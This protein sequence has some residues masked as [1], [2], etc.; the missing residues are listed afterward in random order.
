MALQ[1]VALVSAFITIVSAIVDAIKEFPE[2]KFFWIGG[3]AVFITIILF[4]ILSDPQIKYLL[5]KIYRYNI[6]R[7][8]A[9]IIL[10]KHFVYTYKSMTTLAYKKT[11]TI[12]S[13]V[14][15][16]TNFSDH[17]KWSGNDNDLTSLGFYIN[18]QESDKYPYREC[19]RCRYDVKVNIPKGQT[20]EICMELRTLD[21]SDLKALPFLA[22]TE[23]GKTKKM[24]LDVVFANGAQIKNAT[25]SIYESYTATTAKIIYKLNDS[26]KF[27]YDECN[28]TLTAV[29]YYPIC[30]YKY[31]ISWEFC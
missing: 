30:G 4:I 28:N 26:K 11:F 6:R 1:I 10:S 18:G 15:N 9:Y 22:S 3:L 16:L 5:L 25:Y 8:D 17:F 20:E 29:E 12:K 7:D 31:I 2:A 14:T 27:K 21:N 24:R 13:Q 19:N 23:E